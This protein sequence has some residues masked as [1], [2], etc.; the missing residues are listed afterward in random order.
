MRGIFRHKTLLSSLGLVL[1]LLLGTG[2]ILV[3]VTRINPLRSTYHVTVDLDRSGG[4]QPNNDVT[5]R[6]Y[7]VGKVDSMGFTD[8]GVYA[9]VEINSN[10]KIPK[11]GIVAVQALSAAGEQYIDFRPETDQG[12][13]LTD[14]S[15]IPYSPAK[16]KTPVPMSEVLDSTTHLINEIDPKRYSMM[17]DQLDIALAGGPVQLRTLMQGAS[18]AIAGLDTYLPQTT[19]LI[20]NLGTIMET[21]TN[22]QPD[23]GTL[24]RNSKVIFD[25]LNKANA[26]L[27]KFLDSSPG[28]VSTLGG[29]VDKIS[30]PATKLLGNFVAIAKAGQLRTPAMT[31]LFPALRD[32][33]AGLGT[34]IREGDV[35]IL[36][37]IWVQP[38]CDYA[39]TPT[40]PTQPSPTT[41]IRVYNYC[42]TGIPGLQI[43]GAAN[44]PRP[45]GD[46]TAGPPPGANPNAVSPP[47][48]G[49]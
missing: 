36:G 40:D 37:D 39:S 14:G 33:I 34:T 23:L 47:L 29:T 27:A 19:S 17:V 2:Y 20:S 9:K 44:A 26:E 4:L 49:Q 1:M 5:Y 35:K 48:P 46:D 6:G 28:L 10:Y 15:V 18:I 30:D 11:Q 12:P 43:R 24:T 22:A 31:A 25:Q 38:F 13:Y 21:T 16:I 32:G 3:K 8:K 7:R 45:P 42:Q 41:S